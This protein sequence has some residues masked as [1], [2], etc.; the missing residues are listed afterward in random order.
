MMIPPD[1][2]EV[3]VACHRHPNLSCGNSHAISADSTTKSKWWQS[4]AISDEA[5]EARIAAPTCSFTHNRR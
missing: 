3:D 1:T 5:L 4:V 2:E